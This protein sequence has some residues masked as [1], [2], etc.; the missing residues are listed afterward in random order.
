MMSDETFETK[1]QRLVRKMDE[2][3]YDDKISATQKNQD[4][5]VAINT[6]FNLANDQYH[7]G[8]FTLPEAGYLDLAISRCELV[9]EMLGSPGYTAGPRFLDS[10]RV[11]EE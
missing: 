1:A 4:L 2:V 10:A 9:S 3:F 11:L 8:T 5:I 6:L 7:K